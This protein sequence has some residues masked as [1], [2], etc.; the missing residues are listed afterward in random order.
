MTAADYWFDR[1]ESEA[2]D[3]IERK[4]LPWDGIDVTDRISV[5]TIPQ[6]PRQLPNFSA[7]AFCAG[8][9]S[10]PSQLYGHLKIIRC[11][12]PLE[13]GV[14]ISLESARHALDAAYQVISATRQ[15]RVAVVCNT[16][17]ERS[18]LVAALAIMR[19]QEISG[20][21]ALGIMRKAIPSALKN[22]AYADWLSD[23]QP[24]LRRVPRP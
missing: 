16:G 18:A 11:V 10:P 4:L 1:A 2:E 17:L 5:G 15:G 22:P 21:K 8:D 20:M 24:N 14:R 23:A 6:S 7:I 19:Q 9:L 13:R 12:I 3:R